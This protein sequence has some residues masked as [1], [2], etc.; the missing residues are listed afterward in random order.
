M[1]PQSLPL[2]VLAGGDP[3]PPTLPASGADLHPLK[4]PKGLQL[5]V[6]DRPLIDV[7]LER[8]WASGCFD[9]IFIAGPVS[10][11]GAERGGA[12]VI[13]TNSTFGKNIRR[14]VEMVAVQCPGQSLALTTCDI[15]P[16]VE[17]LQSLMEDY[18]QHAPLDFWFPMIL[19]PEE[20]GELGASAWKPQYRVVTRPGERPR[21]VLPGHLVVADPNAM[22][23]PLVYRAFNL[24][25]K[26]RNRPISYRLVQI[27]GHVFGGLL[28]QDLRHLLGFRLPTLTFTVLRNGI[29]L[30]LNL[31]RGVITPDELA[32]RFRRIFV[33]YRHRRQFPERRGRLPLMTALWL[34]KDID[35]MEEARELTS[36]L[37]S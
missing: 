1:K 3:E 31:R 11:Y 19:T 27:V 20:P 32:E 14:S 28:F 12:Q 25:Y 30:G 24:A 5:K 7:V 17:E 13:D 26:T 16:E 34:A 35:T 36:E 8:L 2:I 29:V 22:R 21:S 37:A 15:L 33:R 9:P 23:R 4:G 10:L 6:G 18:H